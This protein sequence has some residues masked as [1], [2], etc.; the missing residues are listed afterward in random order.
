MMTDKIYTI[1]EI[2]KKVQPIAEKYKLN[3]VSLFGSYARGEATAESDID[4]YIQAS[5]YSYSEIPWVAGAMYSEFE[6][7]FGKPID[8]VTVRSV[9]ENWNMRSTR[10]LYRNI[11]NDEVVLYERR[12]V[13]RHKYIRTYSKVL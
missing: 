4:L 11:K 2:R 6:S 7:A 5:K 10:Y 9:R 12:N 1:D 3:K 8:I 13:Q